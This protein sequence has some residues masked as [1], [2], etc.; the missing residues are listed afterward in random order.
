MGAK[1]ALLKEPYKIIKSN[2]VLNDGYHKI[3]FTNDCKYKGEFKDG[4]R[5]GK[6]VLK[7]FNARYEGDWVD[8]KKNGYGVQVYFN[9]DRYEGNFKDNLKEGFGLYITSNSKYKYKQLVIF[10]GL[11]KNNKVN[12]FSQQV[13]PNGDIYIGE[14]KDGKR[15]GYG[16]YQST[17]GT[18]YEGEWVEDMF[19]GRN[20]V[21][22]TLDRIELSGDWSN[23]S[24]EASLVC[25]YKT[26][27]HDGSDL[28]VCLSDKNLEY[29]NDKHFDNRWLYH[30]EYVNGKREGQG[31][32]LYTNAY[33]SGSWKNDLKNGFGAMTYMPPESG[34][35][36]DSGSTGT[37]TGASVIGSYSGEWVDNKRHGIGKRVYSTGAVYEGS[38]EYDK[39]H[40][41]GVYTSSTSVYSGTTTNNSN[42]KCDNIVYDCIYDHGVL[43]SSQRRA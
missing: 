10:Q 4:K 19:I 29:N 24:T 8:G 3:W 17:N 31:H 2:D 5:H 38:Y 37:G 6:G 22:S 18:R 27:T 20:R 11:W 40:G 16:T 21:T 35:P 36:V 39:R 30:G 43:I 9:G 41:Q 14:F 15:D 33:Y 12:I 26:I 32:R 7:G 25:H 13:L 1:L 42:S 34:V 23:G 28:P